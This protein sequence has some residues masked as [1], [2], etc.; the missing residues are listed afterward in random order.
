MFPLVFQ[1]GNFALFSSRTSDEP[2][3]RG[4]FIQWRTAIV[5]GAKPDLMARLALQSRLARRKRPSLNSL[6]KWTRALS[7]FL[8]AITEAR[9][10]TRA[11]SDAN[12]SSLSEAARP[13]LDE[14]PIK[15]SDFG[16]IHQTWTSDF[17][18][19]CQSGGSDSPIWTHLTWEVDGDSTGQKC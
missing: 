15:I 5:R 12:C 19:P 14:K 6:A 16:T 11:K 18:H 3:A 8:A 17:P 4:P 9:G 10:S 1:A 7:L 2:G 13:R